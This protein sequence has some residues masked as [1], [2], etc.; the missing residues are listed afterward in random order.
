MFDSLQVT[1]VLSIPGLRWLKL[2]VV[3]PNSV[4]E[5]QIQG[6][7]AIPGGKRCLVMRGTLF[8]L[9]IM[10]MSQSGEFILIF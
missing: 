3:G 7:S 6:A 10:A 9:L 8:E 5:S 1:L 2:I 4:P